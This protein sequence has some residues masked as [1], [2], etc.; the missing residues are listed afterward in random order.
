MKIN[1]VP[2]VSFG[3]SADSQ[4][5]LENE[6]S[7]LENKSL[8]SGIIKLSALCNETEDKLELSINE[9]GDSFSTLIDFFLDIKDL[10]FDYVLLYFYNPE[11]YYEKEYEYYSSQESA[12][13]LYGEDVIERMRF[14]DNDVGKTKEE[15]EA[16]LK[17]TKDNYMRSQLI[18]NLETYGRQKTENAT[19]NAPVI[20]RLGKTEFSPNG[21][22]D[23]AGME[24]L[25]QE[26]YEDI[27]EPVN[28]PEQAKIDFEE[29]GKRTPYGILLYGPPGCGKTYI[30]EALANEIQ[31]PVYVI[32]SANTGSKY[33][34]QTANNIK[35]AFE[36]VYAKGEKSKTPVLIFM[37]EIDAMAGSR[38]TDMNDEDIKQTAA[39]LKYIE[40]AKAHNV[41]VI[42]ATNRYDMVDSA[43]RRRFDV[44]RYVGLPDDESRKSLIKNNLSKK[45]KGQKLLQ[46][47]DKISQISDLLEGYSS[48]SINTILNEAS[49][50]ALKRGRADI[51]KSD[52]EEAIK[53]TN[54]EKIN[55]KEYKTAAKKPVLGFNPCVIG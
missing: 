54:E 43:I 2:A 13:E 52:C 38:D 25:K 12:V 44:K 49:L 41:I 19:E 35:K 24:K 31:S 28:N 45:A 20:E 33:I 50:N 18:N 30:T 27:I 8:A 39:L 34:N 14:Y 47:E 11:E 46:D 4:K 37:D 21:F 55:E 7:K 15:L 42:G 48:H 29:Y 17:E 22:S 6:T 5:W 10:L 16:E 32:N 3:Y 53:E 40:E 51:D 36:Y 9:K 1:N 26:L 23:V